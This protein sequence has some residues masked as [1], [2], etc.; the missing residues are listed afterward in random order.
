M[1]IGING[2]S[3]V[4]T[5]APVS[6]LVAH[7]AAAEAAGFASY[8]LGQLAVPDVL[9]VFAAAGA[10]TS[11]IELGTAV[12]PTWTRHP[13][14]LAAQ[15]L[16]TQEACGN[17]LA[18][19]IGLAHK[20]LVEQTLKI[21]FTTPAKH[22]DEYLSVLLPALRDRKVA[23]TGDIWS[24]FEDLSGGARSATPPSVLVAAMGPRMLAMTGERADGSILWLS[25]PRTIGTTIRPA[26][27]A[28]AA[29][30]GRPSPR[31][32][33]GLPVCVTDRP[34]EV[35]SMIAGALATYATLPSYR[36]M[37]DAEGGPGDSIGPAD[38]AI[39]GD[40]ATVTSRLR[41]LA[42]AGATDFSATEFGLS[43]KDF[44]ATRELLAGLARE[45]PGPGDR[46]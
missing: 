17:R 29:A 1:R 7:A 19:G 16:T 28:A 40:A 34:D 14:M 39:V 20:P 6:K 33:A 26:L 8:W 3:L 36:A 22:M 15:A 45:N 43:S 9:T 12:V 2:S 42:D 25:G 23:F 32:V 5:G 35:R 10:A 21:P 38:V 24:G 27:D 18:L 37:L 31:V 41:A 46:A 30:A 4:A 44:A 11:R 13:L